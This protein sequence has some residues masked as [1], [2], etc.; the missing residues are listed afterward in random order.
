MEV[1]QL[2]KVTDGYQLALKIETQ[3]TRRATK[4]FV[5]V[6]NFYPLPRFAP[7]S[8]TNH[9]YCNPGACFKYGKPGHRFANYPRR[10][11]DARVNYVAEEGE[12]SHR[13]MFMYFWVYFLAVD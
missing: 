3:L 11:V 10:Q 13:M 1:H 9:N 6:R 12:P 5:D 8:A 4:K 7:K 2:W